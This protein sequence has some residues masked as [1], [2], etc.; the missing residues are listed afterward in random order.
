MMVHVLYDN[1]VQLIK[2]FVIHGL[3]II[4]IHFKIINYMTFYSLYNMHRK[5][6]DT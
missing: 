1:K 6:T 4:Y 2:R 3:Y 5:I